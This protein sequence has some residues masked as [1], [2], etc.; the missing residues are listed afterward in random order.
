M[1]WPSLVRYVS[2]SDAVREVLSLAS[3]VPRCRLWPPNRYPHRVQARVARGRTCREPRW[4]RLFQ[5]GKV[6]RAQR[7]CAERIPRRRY[8]GVGAPVVGAPPGPQSASGARETAGETPWPCLI[9]YTN[10]AYMTAKWQ[11]SCGVQFSDSGENCTSAIVSRQPDQ[12]RE[13]FQYRLGDSPGS[14]LITTAA[15]TP[16]GASLRIYES[17]EPVGWLRERSRP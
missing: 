3:G 16:R 13:S 6:Y 9:L 1:A 7:P 14:S 5:G 10:N 11:K 2:F 12:S 8:G 15:I 17:A 4:R